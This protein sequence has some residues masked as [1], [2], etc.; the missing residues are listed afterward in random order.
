MNSC[1]YSDE[2][3]EKYATSEHSEVEPGNTKTDCLAR[4][5]L[6][7]PD[8]NY[9]SDTYGACRKNIIIV[10]ESCSD[11]YSLDSQESSHPFQVMQRQRTCTGTGERA[12]SKT[13]LSLL[14]RIFKTSQMPDTSVR[15]QRP[16]WKRFQRPQADADGRRY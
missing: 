14:R 2:I 10:K 6:I 4:Y 12:G 3:K 8:G 7:K 11:G 13:R 9:G 1:F 16:H 15:S 5:L